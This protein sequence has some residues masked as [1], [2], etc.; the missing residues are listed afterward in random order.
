MTTLSLDPALSTAL[1]IALRASVLVGIAAIV[2]A[3]LARWTSAAI[4]HQVW[5]LAVVAIVA[6]PLLSLTLPEWPIVTRTMSGPATDVQ[7]PG[8][9]VEAL[10]GLVG[11]PAVPTGGESAVVDIS[12]QTTARSLRA[13]LAGAYALGTIVL[14]IWFA[15]QRSRLHGLARRATHLEDAD[16]STLSV[17]CARAMGIE[18]PVRLLQTRECRM[19]MAFGVRRPTILMPDIADTWSIERR[20]AVMLHELAHVSRHDCLAQ[21]FTFVACAV[22]WF[23]PAAWWLARR[24]RIER[25]LSCDDRVV[26]AGTPPRE[27]AG[28]LLELAFSIGGGQAPAL[29]VTMARPRQLEGRMRALLDATRSRRVPAWRGSAA[30]AIVAAAVVLPLAT[31]TSR[32]AADESHPGSRASADAASSAVAQPDLLGPALEAVERPPIRSVRRFIYDAAS[33]IGISQ[34][35]LPGTWEIRATNTDGT[36]HLRLNEF[37]SNFGSNIK[38]DQFEGLT[39]AQLSSPG[40]PVQFRLRRDA[41]TFTFEG[42]VRSGVGAGTFSFAPDP[43]FPAE[44]A[45]RGYSQPSALEQYKLARNDTG[46]AFIDE[47]NTQRYQKPQT[48]ELVRAGDHGVSL[49]YLRGMGALGYRLGTL[50]PLIELRDHGVTPGYIRELSAHGYKGLEAEALRRARDHGVTPDYV[51]AMRDN[52]YSSLTMD[53]LIKARDHGVDAEYVR[54]MRQFGYAVSIDEL[55]A[56]RDHGVDADYTR[57]MASLGYS[58]QPLESLRNMRDHGVDPKYVRE[59]KAIGYDALAVGDLITLRDYGLT[60]DRIKAANERAKAR[61]PVELLKQLA[62]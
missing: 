16:W 40:G 52:G 6:L 30:G 23:H 4:R 17:E 45:K 20:R 7:L 2:Q 39:W 18:R 43:N 36:V 14:L 42:V 9:R 13:M 11:G 10:E 32:A 58:G 61:L 46:Y 44:L 1:S 38:I 21:A 3:L 5:M 49:T 55:I 34:D 50:P 31:A 24:V 27:Y 62:R 19:P 15:A 51:Q 54:Q 57:E 59:L 41:G 47:L 28:H 26:A 37:N 48:S 56:A 22:Y 25:E 35:K 29:A 12:A 8:T 33:A 60:A 53:E